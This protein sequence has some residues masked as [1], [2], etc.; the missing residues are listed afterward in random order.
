M[1]WWTQP[2]WKPPALASESTLRSLRLGLEEAGWQVGGG[3][4]R[5][6]GFM[7]ASLLVTELACASAMCLPGLPLKGPDSTGQSSSSCSS[8]S[9]FCSLTLLPLTP[10][11]LVLP[12]SSVAAAWLKRLHN[13]SSLKNAA[14]VGFFSFAPQHP[15]YFFILQFT[16]CSILWFIFLLFSD[17][18]RIWQYIYSYAACA[19]SKEKIMRHMQNF[20]APMHV[21]SIL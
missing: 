10:P 15:P 20:V 5:M 2:G 13:L 9:S 12:A 7:A 6:T 3:V 16:D 8:S 1:A 21:F 18:P 11:T 4:K 17:N 19:A 14:R